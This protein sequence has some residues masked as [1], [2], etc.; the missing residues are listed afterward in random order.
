MSICAPTTAGL[1]S[2]TLSSFAVTCARPLWVVVPKSVSFIR[3]K[4]TTQF[5]QLLAACSEYLSS[6]QDGYRISGCQSESVM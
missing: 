2:R 3:F 4:E 6:H 1:F 5:R